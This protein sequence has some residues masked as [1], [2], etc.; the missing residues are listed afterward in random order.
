MHAHTRVG[1]PLRITS[2]VCWPHRW[3]LQV[4]AEAALEMFMQMQPP[5]EPSFVMPILAAQVLAQRALRRAAHGAEL[6]S[7][8]LACTHC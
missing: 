8:A 7:I 6:A 5:L 4:D 1:A 3:I 2:C